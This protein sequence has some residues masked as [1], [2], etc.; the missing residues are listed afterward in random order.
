MHIGRLLARGSSRLIGGANSD[1]PP[2][3]G[4]H[5]WPSIGPAILVS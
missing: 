2:Y 3:R 5:D 1:E 4:H